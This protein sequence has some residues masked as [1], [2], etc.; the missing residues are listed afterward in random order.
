MRA[1]GVV[2]KAPQFDEL[3]CLRQADEFVLVEAFIT[4]A[5]IEALDVDVLRR[6][7]GC[8]VMQTEV[9]P[10]S[11]TLRWSSPRF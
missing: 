6:L 11:R 7:S 3:A 2:V 1:I 5:A 9:A 10:V 8:D 4:K